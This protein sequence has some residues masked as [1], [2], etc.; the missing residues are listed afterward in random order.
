M[1]IAV[2]TCA[3]DGGIAAAVPNPTGAMGV[4]DA[5]PGLTNLINLP[6]CPVN[7]YNIAA[8]LVFYLTNPAM[9]PDRQSETPHFCLWGGNP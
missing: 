4:K 9:A 3:W 6:G 5:L 1:T 2:G 7:A 8:T